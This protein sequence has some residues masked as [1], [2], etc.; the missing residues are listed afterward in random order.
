MVTI[1]P[2]L[3]LTWCG[4]F[5][6]I[7]C[8]NFGG[9]EYVTIPRHHM[10]TVFPQMERAAEGDFATTAERV[11]RSYGGDTDCGVIEIGRQSAIVIGSV[12][13]TRKQLA[14]ACQAIRDGLAANWPTYP[15]R[16]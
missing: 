7:G 8:N 1:A 12:G 11:V 14:E 4:N 3:S 13:L 16:P 10:A 9:M 2:E 6:T 5:L 15:I